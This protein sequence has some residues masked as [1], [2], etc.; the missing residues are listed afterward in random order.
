MGT[1]GGATRTDPTL[2]TAR[3]I[4]RGLDRTV[5]RSYDFAEEVDGDGVLDACFIAGLT[6]T[7][8]V[9]NE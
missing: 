8:D 9:V 5:G 6:Y 1:L 7:L 3:R 2:R 4:G